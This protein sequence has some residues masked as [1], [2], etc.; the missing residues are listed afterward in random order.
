MLRLCGLYGLTGCVL[1]LFGNCVLR[2]LD[3]VCVET[4][5][6]VRFDWVCVETVWTVRFGWVRVET[7]WNVWCD[8]VW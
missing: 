2:G 6:T 3:W 4:V 7:V 5:W 8:W 1:R